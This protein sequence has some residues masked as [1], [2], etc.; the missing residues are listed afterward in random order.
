MADGETDPSMDLD[1]GMPAN[2][3]YNLKLVLA[4]IN[5]ITESTE[6]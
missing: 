4:P 1:G 3:C 5:I 2:V 6:Y